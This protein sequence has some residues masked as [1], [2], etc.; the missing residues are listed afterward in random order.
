MARMHSKKRGKS[1]SKKPLRKT[2]PT[3]VKYKP[4]E[5]EKLVVKLA[6][7]DKGS[8]EIGTILRDTYGIPDVKKLTKKSITQM[9]MEHEVYPKIPED[10]QNLMKQV[11]N[12][13][14]HLETHKKDLHSTRGLRLIE[15]KIRR[16]VRYHKS[17]GTLPKD[18]KYSPERAKLLVD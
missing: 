16:L 14:K 7:S 10:L 1:S 3:W 17:K 9:M 2:V 5:V 12:L 6:N 13:R 8:A 11:N 15:S 18:W 4:V